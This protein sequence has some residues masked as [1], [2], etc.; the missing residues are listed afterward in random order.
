M[1]RIGF[2]L[3]FVCVITVIVMPFVLP[4]SPFDSRFPSFQPPSPDHWLGTNHLGQDVLTQ[5]IYGARTSLLIGF[6]VALI[7]TFLSASLGLIAGFSKKMDPFINGLGNIL[8]VIPS[9]LFILIIISFTGG[10]VYHLVLILGLSTWAP[11]MRVIRAEVLSLKERE[12]VKAASLFGGRM[13]YILRK[14]LLPHI[15]PLVNTKFIVSFRMA[16][17]TE[18]GVSFLGLGDPNI[19]SLGKMLHQSFQENIVFM[20]NAWSWLVLPPVIF[21]IIMTVAITFMVEKVEWTSKKVKR[22]EKKRVNNQKEGPSEKDCVLECDR[23]S[24][25]LNGQEVLKNISFH[26]KAG[27]IVSIIGPSGIG[28]TTL[29]KAIYGLFSQ[30]EVSGTIFVNRKNVYANDDQSSALHYWHD[31]A[32]ITQDARA[33]MNPLMTIEEQFM[34]VLTSK[35][36]RHT[37][38]DVIS[39]ALKEVNI[40]PSVMQQYPHQ[41]SG[42]M[43]SRIMIALGLIHQPS[44]IIADEATSDLDPV[45][46]RDIMELLLRKVKKTN[47]TLLFITHDLEIARYI[48]DKVIDLGKKRRDYHAHLG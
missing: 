4:L 16:I 46:K 18:A 48:S 21:L 15:S 12:F 23:V 41:L 32:F 19:V 10:S 42:G 38:H 35:Q 43:L 9:M 44:L 7:S 24:V 14:H 45:L 31:I 30:K 26:V 22:Y 47:T 33:A 13:F 2:S 1:K 39:Q 3:L 11:Y 17:L 29:G 20:S 37:K 6:S 25:T 36:S 40:S 5:L 28:K 27:E 8:L 34:E